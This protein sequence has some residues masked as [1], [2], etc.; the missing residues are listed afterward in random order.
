MSLQSERLVSQMQRLRLTHMVSCYESLA[1]EAAQKN[2]PY[3]D[4]LEQLL[5]SEN[6]A[7]YDRNVKLKTQWAH[8]PYKKGLD[9]FEFSFQP[10][11][12]EKK[13]R[14]LA[15]LAFLER[16]ENVILLG[17]P[18][19]G[20]THLAIALGVEAIVA[21]FSVY[22][23]TM[24]DLVTQLVRA[25]EENRLK[26]KMAQL[27]KPKLLILDEIGYLGLDAFGAT[28]LFQ[29]V[30]ERYERGSMI[31]TSNK[32]YGDWGTI[33]ADNVIASAVLD[34]LLH[35]STTLNIKGES[36]RLKDKRKAGVLAKA[37]T[38]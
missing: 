36:Y 27:T 35:H 31:L 9:Q 15:S 8:F 25:R 38:T 32:S 21:G 23:V 20:K 33:F 24:Q 12:D 7:K 5:E 17:P 34:R 14:E 3:L 28:G 2:L 30:S 13:I 6:Q 29:L 10:S 16:K 19:V 18:G 4:F 1:Q 37:A 22:F 11:I 26:E